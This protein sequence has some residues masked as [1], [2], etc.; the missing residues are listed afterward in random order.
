MLPA[1]KM[2]KG[3]KMQFP[4]LLFFKNFATTP[5][6]VIIR[7]GEIPR[8]KRLCQSSQLIDTVIQFKRIIDEKYNI[9]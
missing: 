9:G 4:H 1:L 2:L 7:Y 6:L 5:M 3:D 8:K